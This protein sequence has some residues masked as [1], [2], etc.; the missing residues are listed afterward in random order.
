MASKW[1]ST[2]SCFFTSYRM[3]LTTAFCWVFLYSASWAFRDRTISSCTRPSP[4]RPSS[5][6]P[7]SSPAL[8]FTAAA[9]VTHRPSLLAL[10]VVTALVI[11]TGRDISVNTIFTHDAGDAPF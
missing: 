7:S 2:I 3:Y 10:V 4:L 6:R 11:V 9:T 5:F 8:V 1:S